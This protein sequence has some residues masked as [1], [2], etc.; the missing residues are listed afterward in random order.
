MRLFPDSGVYM[1]LTEQSIA[2]LQ[3][4]STNINLSVH[5][6]RF[7]LSLRA[8]GCGSSN[9]TLRQ[10]MYTR[11]QIFARVSLR[12]PFALHK[13]PYAA[14]LLARGSNYDDPQQSVVKLMRVCCARIKMG[15]EL[16]EHG[17]GPLSSAIFL[18]TGNA[19]KVGIGL[20][21]GPRWVA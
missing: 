11:A 6:R 20:F 15:M 3:S 19:E 8:C 1:L 17:K 2:Y 18:H 12:S 21:I 16:A 7:S 13:Y 9:E 14:Y 4:N 10:M 5:V